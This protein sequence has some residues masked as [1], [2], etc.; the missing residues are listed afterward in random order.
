MTEEKNFSLFSLSRTSGVM[1]EGIH[2]FRIIDVNEREGA[3]GFPYISITLECE[4]GGEYDGQRIWHN[5][6]L[7]PQARWKLEEFL[8]AV[9]APEEGEMSAED[10]LGLRIRA[11]VFH[12]EW[13]G[14]KRARIERA[15]PMEGGE[16]KIGGKQLSFDQLR[17]KTPKGKR[18]PTAD[19]PE[20]VL[21]E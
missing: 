5:V 15:M 21:E 6:S 4:E 16:P 10:F 14:Q 17:G 2:A 20:D 18:K 7:A 19:I 11:T 9:Q 8:D 1:P 3:S 12:E 13:E